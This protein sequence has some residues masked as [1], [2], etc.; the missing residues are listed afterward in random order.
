MV[1]RFDEKEAIALN[2]SPPSR[3][4]HAHLMVDGGISYFFTDPTVPNA[5]KY[6][7]A[8]QGMRFI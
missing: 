7:E 1:S 4:V 8:V 6:T 3:G 2:S 5:D